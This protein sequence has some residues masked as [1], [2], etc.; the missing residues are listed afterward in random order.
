VWGR[1]DVAK[2]R[3]LRGWNVRFSQDKRLAGNPHDPLIWPATD[4]RR[5]VEYRVARNV[6]ADHGKIPII[7]F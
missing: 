7:E 3:Q 5:Q 6:E 1:Y 4:R 2:R